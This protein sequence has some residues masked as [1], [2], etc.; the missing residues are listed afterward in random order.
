MLFDPNTQGPRLFA[1]EIGTDFCASLIQGLDARLA[2]YHPHNQ[3]HDRAR[4]DLL[5]ANGRMQR[6]VQALYMAQGAGFMPRIKTVQSY[7]PTGF[8][9][10]RQR[11]MSPLALRLNL[12]QAIGN[13]LDRFP[14]LAPR[15][16]LYG[17]ADTLA[18]L[19]G[20]MAEENVSTDDILG[21]NVEGDTKYWQRSQQ[22]IALLVRYTQDQNTLTHEARQTLMVTHMVRHWKTNPPQHPI[23][24]AGS[25]GSRGATARLMQAVAHLPQGAVIVPG[26][27]RDMSPATWRALLEGRHESLAGEDHPQYRLSKLADHLGLDPAEI[28]DWHPA[29]PANRARNRAVSLALRPAP[30]TDQ[31]LREGPI[32]ADM[33][34]AF[35]DVTLIEAPNP[36]AEAAAIALRLREAA[37]H[38]ETIALIAPN[39]RL[40]RQVTAALGRWG[41]TPD[42]S[43]G[44]ALSDV[45]G[46]RFLREVAALLQG[47]ANAERLVALLTHP[48]CHSGAGRGLHLLRSR[49]VELSLLRKSA[50]VP[51]RDDLHKWAATRQNDP[52]AKVWADW[53]FDHMLKPALH[54]GPMQV[55]DWVELHYGLAQSIATGPQDDA[56][57]H[58]LFDGEDGQALHQMMDE[59]RAA[60]HDE[61][62]EMN[63]QD[64][65][66]F[67]T[68]LTRDRQAR[69][70]LRPH[71][72]IMIWGTQEA[73]VQGADT[74]ILAG[75]NET[76]WP[77][78]PAADPWLNRTMRAQAGLRLPDRAVGLSAHDFQQAI[79]APTVWLTRALRDDET[80]TVPSRWLNRLTNLLAGASDTSQQALKDMRARGETYLAYAA[81]L[82]EPAQKNTPPAPRPAPAPPAH[83]RPNL[84]SV[85]E[86]EKLIRDPYAVYAARVLRLYPLASLRSDPDMAMRGQVLHKILQD[87]VDQTRDG[88]PDQDISHTL[89]MT[90]TDQVLP[91]Y[92]PWPATRRLWRARIAKSATYIVASEAKRRTQGQPWLLEHKAEWDIPGTGVTLRGTADRIDR[93]QDGRFA[94]YDYKTSKVPSAAEEKSFNKQLWLEAL[95]ATHGA[96]GLPHPVEIA[97]I[98]YLGFG[99][100]PQNLEHCPAHDDMIALLDDFKNR[101]I[102]MRDPHSIF[103]SRRAMFKLKHAYDYDHLARFGEWDHTTSYKPQPV[104]DRDE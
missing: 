46:G 12:A 27:D 61:G 97:K 55:R 99:F 32:L 44:A 29:P 1:T 37:E 81:S 84:L 50:H 34:H 4:V 23:I 57:Q 43:A 60:A 83:A 100:P 66:A 3:A 93:M 26:I 59:L 87:F 86:V 94:L 47:P 28:A 33:D 82:I 52:G 51:D 77:R 70:A 64:Y 6:R 48:V 13:L 25:T 35:R 98:A 36:Q 71:A 69:Q 85:T 38:G 76:S 91:Q 40:I 67:F 9:M 79:G 30:V 41:I 54:T 62:G 65:I 53:V 24:I 78:A 75:L 103:L 73:R 39:Q 80:D 19:V 7:M 42:N 89:L 8:V 88:L 104:G 17:L 95:M 16:S 15:S 92:A 63:A 56:G 49:E 90:I 22:F 101:L 2:A 68:A 72:H 14:D 96:F 21:I 102:H 58:R 18:D 74:M 10:G 45:I 20:E 31:W 11:V 5:V